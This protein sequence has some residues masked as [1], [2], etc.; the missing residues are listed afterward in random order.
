M[1]RDADI[2]DGVTFSDAGALLGRIRYE[3]KASAETI[4][5][6]DDEEREPL[7]VRWQY[8]VGRSAVFASDARDRWAASWTRWRGFDRFWGNVARDLLPRTPREQVDTRYDRATRELVA[9]YRVRGDEPEALP[10][11]LV[12]GPNGFRAVAPVE[13]VSAGVYECRASIGGRFG[14]FRL[15]AAEAVAG[16]PEAGFYRANEE[17][18]TYGADP[19]LLRRIASATGGIFNATPEQIAAAPAPAVRTQ[20]DL[21]PWLLILGLLLN[22]A[23]VAGRKGWLK[24]V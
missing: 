15:R 22:L 20:F 24:W 12:S 5:A 17:L 6:V 21:W 16:F 11:M 9:T 18:T 23:E 1:L 7:F 8:G 2:L 3:S 14:L 19:E 4:L 13:R 10:E